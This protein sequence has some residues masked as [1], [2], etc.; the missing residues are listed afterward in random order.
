MSDASYISNV[1]GEPFVT[2]FEHTIGWITKIDDI[3][4]NEQKTNSDLKV[5]YGGSFMVWL[6]RAYGDLTFDISL[7][8]FSLLLVGIFMWMQVG[9]VFLT[10]MGMFQVIMR[11]SFSKMSVS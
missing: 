5:Y 4:A 2:Q 7:S 6:T 10:C 3:I 1:S 8:F 11:Q 9:S